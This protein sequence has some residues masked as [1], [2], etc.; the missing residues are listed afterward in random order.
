MAYDPQGK[1]LPDKSSVEWDTN[2]TE[3]S[4]AQ[5]GSRN[6]RRYSTG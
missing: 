6:P 5:A 1:R 2:M 3:I 4:S